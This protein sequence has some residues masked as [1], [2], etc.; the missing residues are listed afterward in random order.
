MG[1]GGDGSFFLVADEPMLWEFLKTKL[2]LSG[3]L[4]NLYSEV[5]LPKTPP[6]LITIIG[7]F[8]KFHFHAV[9]T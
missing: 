4:I 8:H 5:V 1:C 2:L 7:T 9:I 3:Y 6:A